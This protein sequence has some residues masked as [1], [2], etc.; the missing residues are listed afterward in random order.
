[1]VVHF[2]KH[3]GAKDK[4]R[5]VSILSSHSA[6]KDDIS[7]VIEAMRGIGSIDYARECA[8]RLVEEAKSE[9]ERLPES[10]DRSALESI[11]SYV[12]TRER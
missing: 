1:M 4:A 6:A 3:A 7:W 8:L 5:L 9:L 2:L 11:A 10:V 12:I